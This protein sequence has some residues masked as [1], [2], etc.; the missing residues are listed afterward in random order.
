MAAVKWIK[1]VTDIFDDEKMLMIEGIPSADSIIVIWFKLLCLAGKS[2]NSGV[3]IFNDRIAYTDEM[4]ATIFRRDVSMVR[5]ALRTFEQFGMIE[6]VDNVITI[7]NW[8]K[9]QTLDAYEKKKERD[10]LR[11]R[12][13]RAQ[14]KA[15]ISGVSP[16]VSP[17]KSPDVAP[18]EEDKEEEK[19]IDIDSSKEEK[20]EDKPPA[21]VPYEE[22]KGMYNEICVSFPRCVSLSDARKKA[23]RARFKS[24]Y[25]LDHFKRLFVKAEASSFLKGKN[26]R[27]WSA[28][29]DWLVKDA[30]MA[31]VLEGNYDDKGYGRKEIVPAW[32]DKPQTAD[33][34]AERYEKLMAQMKGEPEPATVDNDP[35]LAAR[36]ESLRQQLGQKYGKDR[37]R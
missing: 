36:A 34:L 10:R 22:I 18:L 20:A 2:N 1:V 23:I 24:G 3:F 37:E 7:P 26:N 21:P 19:E 33:N 30:N 25:T 11:I 32:M 28:N 5:L 27:N 9:H 8:S 12:E 14:Q 4:L 15:I 6:I 31:K 13:K 29:F 16:D 35:A 17:D